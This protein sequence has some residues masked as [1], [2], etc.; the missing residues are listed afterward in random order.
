VVIIEVEHKS[1]HLKVTFDEPQE[2]LSWAIVG[3]GRGRAGAV[4]WREVCNA[5]LPIDVDPQAWYRAQLRDTFGDEPIVGLLTSRHLRAFE[6][7]ER[8]ADGV[9][10]R[11]VAT[12]GLGNAVR[13]GDRVGS[14]G[15]VGTINI[16]C[17]VSLPLCEE[18]MLETLALANE[19]K[20]LGVREADIPS[21]VSGAP[22]SGTG[23]DCLVIAAKVASDDADRCIYAGKH[24]VLGH[25]VGAAVF[26]A[27]HR[28]ALAWK[29][30]QQA[31]Q[32]TP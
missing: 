32:V 14:G 18:A 27:V 25:L 30:E 16:L 21:I 29:E 19:A 3:G 23:T 6:D 22:A 20:A 24:T 9:R 28:G 26:E 7:V 2:T 31:L 13:A 17:W 4:V 10:V 11:C 8:S 15:T 12:V 5:D 1:P